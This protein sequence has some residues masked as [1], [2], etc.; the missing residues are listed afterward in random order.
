M[1][2]YVKEHPLREALM[3]EVH[4]RP[5]E[6]LTAPER[7]SHIA[8]MGG[9]AGE[10][11]AE[12]H[13]AD[14]CRQYDAPVPAPGA[15]HYSQDLGPFRLR[16]EEHAE[17]CAYTFVRSGPYQHPFEDPVI[18]LVP[19]KWLSTLPGE[20]LAAVHFAVEPRNTP[21]R[22][23]DAL[24]RLFEGN[25][26]IGCY[27]SGGA[28]RVWSD[29]RMHDDGFSRILIRD[30]SMSQNQTGRLVQ[31]V[32]E[33][34]AYRLLAMLAL[35]LAREISPRI[36]KVDAG[37]AKV[38]ASLS[39]SNGG[40]RGLLEQLSNLASELEKIGGLSSYRF[41]AAE[42]YR[43]IVRRRLGEMRQERIEGLQTFSEFLDRRLAP[44]MNSVR[45]TAQR[46][47]SLSG[48]MA[49]V[50]GMIRARVEVQIEEQNRDLLASMDRRAQVQFRL[51]RIVEG[52]SVVAI[53]YYLVSMTKYVLDALKAAGVPVNST[54]GAGIALPVIAGAVWYGL[55]LAHRALAQDE[56]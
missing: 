8:V 26:V 48:R 33:V 3:L 13:L 40:E 37:L 25:M 17:F 32:L 5:F 30:T 55:H 42:A 14:L 7:G 53:T 50:S 4:A 18:N 56:D 1:E 29:L 46:I 49:R 16:W 22:D 11:R 39:D 41:S 15:K 23:S 38:T 54:I 35:P 27:A 20:T 9:E 12:T 28:G 43:D 36:H 2:R 52:L 31:R 51:Q 24:T 44:A 19:K 45:S 21:E 10:N 34:N 6:A 47:E